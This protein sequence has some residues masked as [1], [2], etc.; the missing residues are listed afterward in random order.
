MKGD[1]LVLVE[2]LAE[3]SNGGRHLDPAQEDALLPLEHHVLGPLHKSGQVAL[4]LHTVA[5]SEV[6][7]LLLEQ[8]MSFLLDLLVALSC[9]DALSLNIF[10]LTIDHNIKLIYL[11]N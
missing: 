1:T 3:L 7:G 6:A 9:L 10:S 11:I 2:G 5:H 8:R 4:G